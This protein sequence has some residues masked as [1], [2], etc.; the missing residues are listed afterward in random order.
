MEPNL[1]FNKHG[2]RKATGPS[3]RIKPHESGFKCA[4]Y[5]PPPPPYLVGLIQGKPV[6]AWAFHRGHWM[7]PLQKLIQ[8]LGSQQ[9]SPTFGAPKKGKNE[10]EWGM[11]L[12]R[13][14]KLGR[15]DT[16][17]RSKKGMDLGSA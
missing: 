16:K 3:P 14:P 2:S 4:F 12:F 1:T 17:W 8:L 10:K 7:S 9:N 6:P 5:G 11:D 13:G 15:F